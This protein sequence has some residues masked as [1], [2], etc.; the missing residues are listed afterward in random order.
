MC[1]VSRRYG[2]SKVSSSSDSSRNAVIPVDVERQSKV[3]SWLLLKL[4]NKGLKSSELRV[5]AGDGGASRFLGP[6]VLKVFK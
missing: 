2:S 4:E 5:I 6:G 3:L 1:S